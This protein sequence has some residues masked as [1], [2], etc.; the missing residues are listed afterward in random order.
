[1]LGYSYCATGTSCAN[2]NGNVQ[3]QTITR[4]AGAWSQTYSYDVLNRLTG[5]VETSSGT[6]TWSEGYQYDSVGN[7]WMCMAGQNCSPLRTGLPNMTLETATAQSWYDASK[8]RLASW[9]YDEA[10]NITQVNNMARSFAYDAESRQTSATIA[11]VVNTYTYDGE[12]RRVTRT[13]PWNTGNQTTVYVYDA[14]GRLAAE[15]GKATDTGT[16]Y[17]T[18]DMLGS[19]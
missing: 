17:L 14:M 8:N 5:V 13:T 9:Q 18:A 16:K 2:N 4:P 7:R 15:Y 10:G 12:G 1:S 11:G 3:S 19:T 6:T